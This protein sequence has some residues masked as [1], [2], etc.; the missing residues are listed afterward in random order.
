[1]NIVD[2]LLAIA[3][4]NDRAHGSSINKHLIRELSLSGTGGF[5]NEGYDSPSISFA[6]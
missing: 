3:T 6:K 4:L 2:D 5:P 1:M